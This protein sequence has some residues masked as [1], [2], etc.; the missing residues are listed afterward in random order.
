[1]SRLLLGPCYDAATTL[2]ARFDGEAAG[3]GPAA[4]LA[5]QSKAFERIA[6]AWI[7]LVLSHADAR[8]GPSVFFAAFAC[9]G[10]ARPL[11]SVES[12]TLSVA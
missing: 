7:L 3:H 2:A 4:F 6:L 8:T 1:M 5:D 9:I 10:A 11:A 12:T